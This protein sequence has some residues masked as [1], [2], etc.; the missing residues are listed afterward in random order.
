MSKCME[1]AYLYSINV[2]K[3]YVLFMVLVH[4]LRFTRVKQRSAT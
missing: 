3:F 2:S 1:R 4:L